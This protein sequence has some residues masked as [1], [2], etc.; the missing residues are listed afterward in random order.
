V[1]RSSSCGYAGGLLNSITH[2]TVFKSLGHTVRCK[3]DIPFVSRQYHSSYVTTISLLLCHDSVT[4]FMSHCYSLLGRFLVFQLV[5]LLLMSRLLII[6][7]PWFLKCHQQITP[8]ECWLLVRIAFF[9]SGRLV[10]HWSVGQVGGCG[11]LVESW[12]LRHLKGLFYQWDRDRGSEIA[13]PWW[14]SDRYQGCL[15]GWVCRQRKESCEE[16]RLTEW[17][18]GIWCHVGVGVA[19]GFAGLVWWV[20]CVM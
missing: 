8:S 6:L 11:S 13:L 19:S 16:R 20:A 12:L 18:K 14:L 4:P 15:L 3:G 17:G 9:Y 10:C 2:I 5:I 7:L 1:C